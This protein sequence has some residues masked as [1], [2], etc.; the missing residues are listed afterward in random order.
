MC[1]EAVVAVAAGCDAAG[2]LHIEQQRGVPGDACDHDDQGSNSTD[3][4]HG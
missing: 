2:G 1:I 4:G 3:P